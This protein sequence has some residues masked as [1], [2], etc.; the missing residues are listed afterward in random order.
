MENAWQLFLRQLASADLEFTYDDVCGWSADEFDALTGAGLLSEAAQATYVACDVCPDAHWE[1][2]LWSE[3]GHRAF[4]P[5][6]LAGT[7]DVDLERLRRWRGSLQQLAVG[8]SEAL[9]PPGAAQPLPAS[10]IWFLGRRRTDGRTP[11]FFFAA[12]GPD[13]LPSAVQAVRQAYGRVV[14]VLFVPFAP[15]TSISGG[16]LMIVD[17]GKA[18]T[19]QDRRMTVDLSF[20]DEQ[21]R[22]DS[23]AAVSAKL[24]QKS[25][26][27]HRR[28]ILRT[29]MESEEIQD[30]DALGTRLRMDRSVLSGMV[31]SDKRK[32]GETRLKAMLQKIGCSRAKWDRVPRQAKQV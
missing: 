23:T 29:Y 32:Y 22:D 9:A 25:L 8:L 17:V 6:P 5:C 12:I 14:A 3:D 1:R 19:L 20:V 30:M 2:V 18:A 24:A 13:E 7:L 10:R 26:R 15:S 4:I 28:A 11:Y 21:L 27:A 31:R 16:K